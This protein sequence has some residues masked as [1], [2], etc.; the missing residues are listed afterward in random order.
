[1][2]IKKGDN[3][4]IIVGKDRGKTGKVTRVDNKT[5]KI[6]VEGLNLYKKHVRPKRQGE[7]GEVVA[8]ARPMDISNVAVVCGSC[9][10][11]TRVGSRMEGEKK[12]RVCA[13]CKATI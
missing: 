5:T 1:M 13:K 4:K 11:Q 12:V 6:F 8:I 3:V 7:K 9:N 2:N 10:K